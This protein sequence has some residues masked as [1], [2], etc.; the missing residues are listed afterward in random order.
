MKVTRR[1][2]LERMPSVLTDDHFAV[3]PSDTSLATWS[4]EDLADLDDYVRHMLHS[5]RSKVGRRFRAFVQYVR[6]PMG[7]FV[8]LYA[9]LIF[10]VGTAWIVFLIGWVS[11]GN[12][13]EQSAVVGWTN[14]GLVTLCCLVG[15]CL[16]PWR[17]VDTYHLIYIVRWDRFAMKQLRAVAG[18]T[19]DQ[20]A[21]GDVETGSDHKIN[22][23][24][25]LTLSVLSS[26]QR[27]SLEY[28]QACFAKSH[29]FYKPRESETHQAFPLR[30]LIAIVILLDSNS[31]LQLT[32]ALC[33]WIIPNHARSL[34]L[35]ISL[36]CCGMGCNIAGGILI[37]IGDK[38]TRKKEAVERM[39]RQQLTAEAIRR[40]EAKRA[41]AERKKQKKLET[42]D[43]ERKRRLQHLGRIRE[44][45]DGGGGGRTS[46]QWLRK[47]LDVVRGRDVISLANSDRSLAR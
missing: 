12:E 34:A 28:H 14:V 17:A 21:S 2:P 26:Q 24:E 42:E 31:I 3:R 9:T 33:A 11:L 23:D 19:N 7:F 10:L 41:K 30:L 29:T 1:T 4:D 8:T 47:S 16:A 18:S 43:E 13:D 6:K 32:L 40:T 27:A 36:L 39:W 25:D 20:D 35:T 15:I 46:S 38:R 5:R 45:E 44:E 22:S 37:S